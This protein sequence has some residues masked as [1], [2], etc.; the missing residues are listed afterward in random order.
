M[1]DQITLV[2]GRPLGSAK[3]LSYAL[4]ECSASDIEVTGF[5]AGGQL[6]RNAAQAFLSHKEVRNL[7][8]TQIVGDRSL[9]PLIRTFLSLPAA[10]ASACSEDACAAGASACAQGRVTQQTP[11]TPGFN[12]RVDLREP[13]AARASGGRPPRQL[14][15]ATVP[16]ALVGSLVGSL[17][18]RPPT[19]VLP[20]PSAPAAQAGSPALATGEGGH[21]NDSEPQPGGENPIRGRQQSDSASAGLTQVEQAPEQTVAVFPGSEICQ[22]GTQDIPATA[23][24][25]AA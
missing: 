23:F 4:H 16:T 20:P 24:V 8:L 11:T 19:P 7:Q 5:F 18:L 6:R 25:R 9:H 13:S 21:D 2:L 3:I 12:L 22:M 10:G 1:I 15:T 17:P 14:L